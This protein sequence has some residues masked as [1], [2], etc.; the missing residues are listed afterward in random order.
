M[1]KKTKS[2]LE[3]INSMSPKRDRKQ[4]I[5]TNASQVIGTAIN[6]LEMIE[7]QYEPEVAADLHKRLVN[8]IKTKD[9]KKFSR[10]IAKAN[11]DK[12]HIGRG[13]QETP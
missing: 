6:L 4:L 1:K 10:G 8:S 9:P 7:Q 5:E 3:E 11:E 12:R 2:L 13:P